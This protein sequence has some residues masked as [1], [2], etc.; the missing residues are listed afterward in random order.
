MT[1]GSNT[2]RTADAAALRVAI[3]PSV[4]EIWDVEQ[5]AQVAESLQ[6]GHKDDAFRA[7]AGGAWHLVDGEEVPAT[8]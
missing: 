3:W 7:Q 1:A 5:R 6:L 4:T 2:Y 8:E